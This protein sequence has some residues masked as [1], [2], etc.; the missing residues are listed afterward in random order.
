MKKILFLILSILTFAYSFG[1]APQKMSYQAVI[2]NTSNNLV[3]NSN[4]GMKISILQGSATGSSVYSETHAVTSNSNGLVTIEIGTGNII[5]GN[6]G[7]INWGQGPYF[8]KTETDIT[9]GSNYT[10]IATSQ[11]LSVPYALYAENSGGMSDYAIFEEQ[12][13]S[14]NIPLLNSG[15]GT[16]IANIHPMN[17]IISQ[18]GNSILLNNFSGTITLSPGNYRVEIS[19]PLESGYYQ[20]SYLAFTGT[21]NNVIYS[22]LYKYP[23]NGFLNL[24]GFLN[25]NTTE[26]FTLNQ[27]VNYQPPGGAASS[28]TTPLPN[29]TNTAVAKIYIYKL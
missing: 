20:N 13:P 1:Q 15:L 22:H 14:G 4:V 11:L 29:S 12:Y 24:N 2:R 28:S 9:G 26:T 6:F 23:N 3:S 27:Y 10:L 7:S 17:T 25:I 8:I 18:K 21:L 5:S 16:Y 19:S